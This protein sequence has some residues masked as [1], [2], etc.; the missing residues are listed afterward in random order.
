MTTGIEGDVDSFP[1]PDELWQ[2]VYHTENYWRDE[3]TKIPFEDKSGTWQPRYYQHNAINAVLT[4]IA[5]G[6]KRILLTMATGTGKTAIAFQIAWKLFNSKWN[7]SRQP[8]RRPRILFLAD[9]NIL[10]DQAFNAFSGFNPDALIRINPQEIKKTGKVPKNGSIFFT[11]FQTFNC[12]AS[13]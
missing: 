6:E 8:T 4:K 9:R 12:F 11:I 1:S 10:A 2:R 7:L 5:E 13:I 3:F